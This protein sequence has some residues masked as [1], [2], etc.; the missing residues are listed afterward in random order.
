MPRCPSRKLDATIS[1]TVVGGERIGR[2]ELP[3][4]RSLGP[5]PISIYSC[6]EY[7]CLLDLFDSTRRARVDMARVF[8]CHAQ[9]M[10]DSNDIGHSGNSKSI[11][12][13]PE[14]GRGGGEVAESV[15]PNKGPAACNCKQ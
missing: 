7:I 5:L 11:P 8:V 14:M 13:D 15:G 12:S 1:S 2:T 3:T 6:R 10:R 9:S 4:R